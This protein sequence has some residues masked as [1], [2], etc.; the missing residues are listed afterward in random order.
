MENEKYVGKGW[1][2]DYGI[3]VQLKKEDLLNLPTNAYG[4]IEVFVGQRKEVDQKSKA[5]HWVKWK[6]KDAPIQ[7]ASNIEIHPALTKAG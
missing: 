7:Q 4:D 3:K 5:T 1:K 2:N 6:A